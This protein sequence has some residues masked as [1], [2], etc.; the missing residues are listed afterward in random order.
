MKM[1]T[2]NGPVKTNLSST[3]VLKT[4]QLLLQDN[5]TMAE[6]IEKLNENEDTPVFNNSVVSKY[7]NTCRFCR[8]D[9]HKISG[10]YFMSKNPFG[11]N[12]SDDEYDL[13]K[14]LNECANL[15]LSSN[16]SK[17]MEKLVYKI[18]KYSNREMFRVN[19]NVLDKICVSFE[20]AIQ[21]E[22][23]VKLTLKNKTE[24][25]CVPIKIVE[26]VN[27]LHF[28]VRC[29][30]KD[31][32]ILVNKISAIEILKERF[33]NSKYEG[34]V[35]YKLTGNLAKNYNLRENEKIIPSDSK[36]SITVVNT[37]ENHLLL[38]PRLL[39]YGE[40]CEIIMPK[41]TREEIK[42]IIDKTLANYGE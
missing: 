5:Y 15:E 27:G 16:A 13:L 32:M 28:H 18:C 12:M 6:L 17:N 30:D 3:Q 38:I 8:M 23:K 20:N 35:I 36:E 34:S 14:D 19:D 25:D 33:R 1:K 24:L 11:M 39:R 41:Y 10:K 7:I 37:N 42:N 4:L 26:N 21:D 40:L 22:H 9:I 29:L 31:K 2:K